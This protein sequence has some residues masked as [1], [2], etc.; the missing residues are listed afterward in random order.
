MSPQKALDSPRFLID[1]GTSGGLI[2]TLL[3]SF[4][5]DFR[6][7]F[8]EGISEEVIAELRRKGHNCH[9]QPVKGQERSMFGVGQIII[10]EVSG[11]LTAGSD[12]RH[13][14]QAVGY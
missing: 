2:C 12:P 13:D 5:F 1:G 9:M 6:L 3:I 10:R 14:G 4:S 7:D 11:V 8:E